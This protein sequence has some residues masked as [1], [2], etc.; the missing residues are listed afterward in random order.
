MEPPFMAKAPVAV[1]CEP[2]SML[3]VPEP[4]LIIAS[5]IRVARPAPATGAPACTE[6]V[7][8]EEVVEV[9]EASVP[10]SPSEP[11][12]LNVRAVARLM[13][14]SAVV[15]FMSLPRLSALRH[16]QNALVAAPC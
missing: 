4:A 1:P 8:P 9:V 10:P 14:A 2:S 3:M 11:Q 5:G 15:F 6:H 13:A 12:P 7:M 16:G